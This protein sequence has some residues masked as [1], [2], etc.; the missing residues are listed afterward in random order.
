[1]PD[2]LTV[3]DVGQVP[4]LTTKQKYNVTLRSTFD[5]G[6]YVFCAGLAGV[7]QAQDADPSYGQGVVSYGKRFGLSFVDNA[8][9]NFF[10]SAIVPSLF[11]QDP[12][13]YRMGKGNVF[14]R[15]GYSVSR[16][17]VTRSDAGH[18]QFN[19]SEI[20][21]ALMAAGVYN[22]YHPSSDRTVGNT[23]SSWVWQVGYDM[24]FTVIREFWPRAS[25]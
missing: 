5:W 19:V 24:V 8:A 13:Y 23:I 3:E 1:L 21:G 16:I 20:G 11:H 4:P 15:I 22:A 10:T 12:R 7:N 25:K 6:Q 9:E 2:F 18:E 14:H 17:F